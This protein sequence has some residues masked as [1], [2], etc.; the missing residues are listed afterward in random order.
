VTE[1]PAGMDVCART[2][3]RLVMGLR[4]RRWPMAGLQFHPD[5]FLTEGGSK[6]LWNAVHGR[7]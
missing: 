5:S 6:I 3:D 2:E 4:H 7:F 1:V